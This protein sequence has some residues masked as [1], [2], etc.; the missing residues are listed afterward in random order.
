M[1]L[2]SVG[3]HALRLASGKLWGSSRQ[4]CLNTTDN[5]EELNGFAPNRARRA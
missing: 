4:K 2:N 1:S 5:P 3:E